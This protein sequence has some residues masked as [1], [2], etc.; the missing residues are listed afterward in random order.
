MAV[1]NIEAALAGTPLP[2]PF[3]YWA[4]SKLALASCRWTHVEHQCADVDQTDRGAGQQKGFTAEL[5]RLALVAI[6]ETPELRA[7]GFDQ[8]EQ[9]AAVGFLIRFG[10][11][12]E[13][14]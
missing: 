4:N 8:N 12:L 13:G 3:R 14:F 9:A 2:P 6:G 7:I 5:A 1:E 10:L 11:R